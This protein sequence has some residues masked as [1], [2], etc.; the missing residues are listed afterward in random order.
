MTNTVI[1]AEDIGKRYQIKSPD[2]A[3][4]K[5]LRDTVQSTFKQFFQS[6]IH[7]RKKDTAF[8]ALKDINFE[9]Q[10][11]EKIGIIGPNGAGKSTLLKILSRITLPSVG[12]ITL[13]GRVGTLL[14]VGTGFHPELTGREN[15]FLSGTIL[16]MKRFEIAQKLDEIVEFAGVELFLDT[17]VKRYSSGMRVRLGFAVAAHLEPE[18]LIVDEVLAV[19]DAAFQKKCLGRMDE[20]AQ[21]GRTVL[22]VSHNLGMVKQLCSSCLLLA[23]GQI[24]KKGPPLEV[25]DSYLSSDFTPTNT[26]PITFKGRLGDQVKL[27]EVLAKDKKQSPGSTINVSPHAPIPVHFTFHTDI[28]VPFRINM[29]I[30]KDNDRII[31]AFDEDFPKVSNPVAKAIFTIPEKFLRPGIYTLS[32]GG[33]THGKFGDWFWTDDILKI[34]VLEEWGDGVDFDNHGIINF[35][36]QAQRVQ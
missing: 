30:L 4:Y 3:Y 8:W 33:L 2:E 5:S 12:Q 20:I 27:A 24:I 34:N 16:G 15:I 17:P 13:K 21:G 32:V 18:I 31:T 29:A 7:S 35:K 25:I 28:K 26:Q 36:I 6:T 19:G 14:E 22:F 10:R 9:V 11:G 1:R 23:N